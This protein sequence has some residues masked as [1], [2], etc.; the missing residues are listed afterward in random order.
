MYK[1]KGMSNVAN[2]FVAVLKQVEPSVIIL[3][4]KQDD[5]LL[6]VLKQTSRLLSDDLCLIGIILLYTTDFITK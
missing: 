6:K 4:S 3:G 1:L 5:R 2:F